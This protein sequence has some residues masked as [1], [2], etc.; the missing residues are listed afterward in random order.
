MAWQS[1]IMSNSEDVININLVN[2]P[3]SLLM[4]KNYGV[5]TFEILGWDKGGIDRGYPEY[6]PDQRLGTKEDFKKCI[7]QH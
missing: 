4:Q 7:E 6:E 1:I 2:C 5:T 3:N